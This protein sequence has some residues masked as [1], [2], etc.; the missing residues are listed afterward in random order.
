[1]TAASEFVVVLTTL[2]NPTQARQFVQQLVDQRLI[3]CGTILPGATSVYRWQGKV[4]AEEEAVVLLKTL[5]SRW[6]ALTAAVEA[7]HPYDLPELLAVPL[8]AGLERYLQWVA[9]E[10]S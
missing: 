6:D 4:T 3:A 8:V 5:K 10:A 9:S 1:M 2:G 7:H